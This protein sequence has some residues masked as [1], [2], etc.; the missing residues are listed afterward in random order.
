MRRI[1]RNIALVCT[2][3]FAACAQPPA[4]EPPEQPDTREADAAEIHAA[5]KNWSAAA[6]AKDAEAFVSVYV[7][8]AVLMLEGAPN[9]VGVEA[10]REGMSG[11]MQDPNFELSFEADQVKVARSGDLAYE[12]GA[13]S[14]T[15]S[16]P[17]ENP[18][19][20]K[21]HYVVVWEKQADGSWKVVLDAPVSDPPEAPAPE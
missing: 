20:Q 2:F 8:D 1:S 18:A 10:I 5:V 17:E 12:T 11:M 14:L 6:Q 3:V 9:L 15:M 21:G 7:D 13:Y 16:D 19:T 4:A